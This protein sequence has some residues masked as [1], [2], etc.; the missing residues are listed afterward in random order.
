MLS[1]QHLKLVQKGRI[2]THA[3]GFSGGFNLQLQG[4]M[5]QQTQVSLSPHA[6]P[7]IEALLLHAFVISNNTACPLRLQQNNTW[8]HFVFLIHVYYKSKL[9]D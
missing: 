2:R 1:V 3:Q 9:V 8:V 4:D 6:D 7:L 5:R